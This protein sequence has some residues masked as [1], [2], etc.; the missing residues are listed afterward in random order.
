MAREKRRHELAVT[1]FPG[2]RQP[3]PPNFTYRVATS[4]RLCWQFLLNST[5]VQRRICP[6]TTIAPQPDLSSDPSAT[7]LRLTQKA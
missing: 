7:H 5:H 2:H 4:S 3:R 1:G 6:A